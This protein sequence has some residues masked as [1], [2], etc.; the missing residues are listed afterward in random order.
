MPRQ[1]VHDKEVE[2]SEK[3]HH[4]SMPVLWEGLLHVRVPIEFPDA[5]E[6]PPGRFVVSLF[7]VTA[8][9]KRLAEVEVNVK[10]MGL[11]LLT[12]DNGGMPTGGRPGVIGGGGDLHTLEL[13]LEGGTAALWLDGKVY[14][15]T[16]TTWKPEPGQQLTLVL[17]REAAWKGDSAPPVGFTYRGLGLGIGQ[18]IGE[19]PTTEEPAPQPVSEAPPA[20]PPTLAQGLVHIFGITLPAVISYYGEMGA[21][22]DDG[23]SVAEVAAR[24]AEAAYRKLLERQKSGAWSP[25]K[26]RAL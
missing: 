6:W 14:A 24:L 26:W 10:K 8:G 5:Q 18:M 15:E 16:A 11:R 7:A 20:G 21:A 9:N 13:V 25:E 4:F 1:I 2:W 17:G 12:S 3:S 22:L 19:T 23:E